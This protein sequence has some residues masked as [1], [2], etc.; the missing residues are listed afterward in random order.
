MG[1]V[2]ACLKRGYI[3]LTTLIGTIS[4]LLLAATLFGHGYFYEAEEIDELLPG[5]SLLYALGVITLLLSII[6]VYGAS[7]EKNWALIVFTVGMA[8][9]SLTMF[10]ELMKALPARNEAGEE[11]RREHLVMLPLNEA[12]ES[13]KVGLH[14]LQVNLECCGLEQGYQDWGYDIPESCVC[15][16]D[17]INECMAA[18]KNSS[19]Y[20]ESIDDKLIRIYK[21]PCLPI[22]LSHV[23]T[24][25]NFII[26]MLVGLTVLWMLSAGLC[27]SILCQLRRRVDVPP[28]VYSPEAK[29]GNYTTLTDAAENA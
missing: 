7:K 14:N 20:E 10:V 6:G 3:I 1:K 5:I 4:A 12:S 23:H 13:D 15:T 26:A 28:V 8:L 27:V 21:E 17:T 29:A 25:I 24:A 16:E 9:T 2:N 22:L 18:P 19:L 11:V